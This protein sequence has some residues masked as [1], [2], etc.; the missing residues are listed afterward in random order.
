MIET[1]APFYECPDCN[2]D[3]AIESHK[4]GCKRLEYKVLCEECD[5]TGTY[6]KVDHVK[7][8][9][10][11]NVWSVCPQCRTPENVFRACDETG[12]WQP[13]SCGTPTETGYRSTCGIHAPWAKKPKIGINQ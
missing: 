8:P 1:A 5:W 11:D 9:K 10:S 12:C 2:A 7:D 3:L 4:Q 6:D 13:V